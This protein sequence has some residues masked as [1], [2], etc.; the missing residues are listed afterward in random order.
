MTRTLLAAFFY[1]PLMAALAAPFAPAP[2]RA[3]F[4]V[5]L[6]AGAAAMDSTQTVGGVKMIDQGGDYYMGGVRIGYDW[7]A[8]N[9]VFVGAEGE[10]FL[11]H[12][13]S[14]AL[15]NGDL[16]SYT[17]RGGLGAYGRLGWRT[18]DSNARFFARAGVLG[19]NTNSGWDMQPAVGLGAEVPFGPGWAA[20]LDGTYS[21]GARDGTRGGIEHYQ[22]TGGVVYRF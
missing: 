18:R 7:I 20:R 15:V 12:G 3:D 21:W 14:R 11:G 8:Q 13:R 1:A 16:F 10:G 4:F 5:N 19:L 6:Y 17:V 2:A 9:G 22:L